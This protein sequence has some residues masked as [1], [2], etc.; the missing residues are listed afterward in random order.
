MSAFAQQSRALEELQ[1][2]LMRLLGR[3]DEQERTRDQKTVMV[4]GARQ[5]VALE[6]EVKDC[7]QVYQNEVYQKDIDA[8]GKLLSALV[9]DVVPHGDNIALTLETRHK[10]MSLSVVSVDESGNPYDILRDAGGSIKNVVAMGLRAIAVCKAQ[11]RPLLVLDEPDHWVSSERSSLFFNKVAS[12]L[13][14]NLGFQVFAISHHVDICVFRGHNTTLLSL[15]GDKETGVFARVIEEGRQFESDA[16]PGI[17]GIHLKNFATYVDAFIPF[18]AGVT[19]LSGDNDMGKSRVMRAL[20][21]VCFGGVE[22]SDATIRRGETS[23]EVTLHLENKMRL[24]WSRNPKRN[25][26]MHWSLVD[27]KN[28]IISRDGIPCSGGGINGGKS[29]PEWVADVLNIRKVDDLDIQL[30]EQNSSLFILDNAIPAQ[31]KAKILSVGRESSH[32][33][34]L[35]RQTSTEFMQY[36]SE[37]KAGER[38]IA[39]LMD[40]IR[41]LLPLRGEQRLL[42]ELKHQIQHNEQKYEQLEALSTCYDNLV[43]GEALCQKSKDNIAMIGEPIKDEEYEKISR[44][45]E[46][47]ENLTRVLNH[48]DNLNQNIERRKDFIVSSYVEVPDIDYASVDDL[49]RRIQRMTKASRLLHMTQ[50]LV[51]SPL[52][53]VPEVDYASVDD[54]LLRIRRME[55]TMNNLSDSRSLNK[56][57]LVTIPQEESKAA[58]V[59]ELLSLI[60]RMETKEQAL[61]VANEIA[62]MEEIIVVEPPELQKTLDLEV[63]LKRMIET[64]KALEAVNKRIKDSEEELADIEAQIADIL[65]DGCPLCGH[66]TPHNHTEAACH[67]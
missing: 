15:D 63:R 13:S 4:A 40:S 59:D 28:T 53:E 48:M 19:I 44:L 9:K 45:I 54:L 6:P 8:C 16:V 17:R 61:D 31:K 67:D 65:A 14:S 52:V 35:I 36:R 58:Q 56:Y 24:I 34:G 21:S 18:G 46:C 47:H 29:P 50:E 5:K 3:L 55:T 38:E 66:K 23:T 22:S 33:D 10:T 51:S 27:E 42:D 62:S 7:L 12:Q 32:L 25:P 57:D 39:A 41:T 20:R 1:R 37:I 11:L 49:L 30:A 26:T 43:Q 64:E 2:S 60:H